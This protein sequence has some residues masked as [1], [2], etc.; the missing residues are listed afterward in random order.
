[1][2][3]L[4]QK[5]HQ[6]GVP[7]AQTWL[8]YCGAA[9]TPGEWLM[10]WNLDPVLLVALGAAALLGRHAARPARFWAAWAL[11][12]LLFLSPLC[13]LSS[14]L[15]SVRVAHHAVLIAAVAPLLAGAFDLPRPRGGVAA[16]TAAHIVVLWMWHSPPLYTWALA[17]DA[18]F[19]L[20]QL[21]LLGSAFGFWLAVRRAPE[22]VAAGALL[23]GM[24]QMGLLGALITFA[25]SPLYAP[26]L[27]TTVAWGF[28]PLEDQQLA[29][30]IMWAPAAL[31]YLGSALFLLGR[32]LARAEQAPA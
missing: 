15:F 16:W 19:W 5:E 21:S 26:H 6:P 29:G 32:A 7:E 22:L 1:M 9:P 8:P 18:A 17:S 12:A 23:I 3:R 30:L 27:L 24:M 13:A 25:G 20:M 4:E 10:R 28:S 11:T 31:A 2:F 14:A